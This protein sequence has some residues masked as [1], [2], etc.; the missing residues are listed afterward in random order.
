MSLSQ[1]DIDT[2]ASLNAPVICVDTCTLLDVIRD[3][4]RETVTVGDAVAGIALLEAA[5]TGNDL[6]VLIAEQVT[7]E[8]AANAAEVEDEANRSLLK[9]QS[10]LK[11]IYDVTTAY[12]TQGSLNFSCI[13]GH[14]NTA[15]KFLNRWTQIT[16]LIPHNPGISSR[17]F[18]RVNI[19]KTP[20]RK[21]K[22]SMKDCVVVETY[23]EAVQQLRAA[24]LTNKVVFA[25]SNTREYY[26]PN[27]KHLATDIDLDFSQIGL[28]YAPSFGAA[29]HILGI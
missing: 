23:L 29:K 11:R 6:V 17:A 26:A 1:Q 16:K 3:I 13:D 5:E 21:G 8:I 25:S 12:G 27:I 20:A 18:Q 28:S 9:L 10:Q 19:P 15:K 14:V 24:G 4:T 2:I 22:E 7:I